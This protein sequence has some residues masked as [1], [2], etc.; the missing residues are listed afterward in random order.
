[1]AAGAIAEEFLNMLGITILSY[2]KEIGGIRAETFEK[3]QIEKNAFRMP[4]ELAARKVEEYL[5]EKMAVCDSVGGIIEC[6]ATGVPPTWG[7]P[8]FDSAESVNSNEA[9]SPFSHSYQN[10]SQSSRMSAGP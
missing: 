6:T 4:D 7:E 9:S 10:P 2:A 3:D 1:M 8:F 5:R